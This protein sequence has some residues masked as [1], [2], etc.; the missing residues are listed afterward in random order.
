MISE[1]GTELAVINPAYFCPTCRR[2]VKLVHCIYG[3]FGNGF[4]AFFIL[5]EL[6]MSAWMLHVAG[7]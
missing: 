4:V 2:A 1:G 5:T 7:N 3:L 6:I